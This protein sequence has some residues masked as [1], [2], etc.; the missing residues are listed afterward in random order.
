MYFAPVMIFCASLHLCP[1]QVQPQARIIFQLQM[2]QFTSV[3]ALVKQR[4]WILQA[5]SKVLEKWPCSRERLY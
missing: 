4:V 3:L 5:D 1:D 2:T